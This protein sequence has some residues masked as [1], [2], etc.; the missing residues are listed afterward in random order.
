MS[1]EQGFP[2]AMF[3]Y[4][5]CCYLGNGVEQNLETAARWYQKA[6]DAGYEPDDEDRKHLKEVL[7]ENAAAQTEMETEQESTLEG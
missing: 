5:D 7:G 4:G 3:A 1:A 6:L 2:A